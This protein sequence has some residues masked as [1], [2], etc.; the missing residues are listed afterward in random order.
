MDQKGSKKSLVWTH[1]KLR[2]DVKALRNYCEQLYKHDNAKNGTSTFQNHIMPLSK[3][4][5]FETESKR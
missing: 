4:Y 3:K 1:F 5:R 2:R